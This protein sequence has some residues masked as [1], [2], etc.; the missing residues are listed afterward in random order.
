M[1]LQ[2]NIYGDGISN[3]DTK[4]NFTSRNEHVPVIEHILEQ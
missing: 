3:T 1:G 4:L 2:S